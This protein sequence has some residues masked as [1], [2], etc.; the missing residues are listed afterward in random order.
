MS[1]KKPNSNS[2][3]EDDIGSLH[4]GINRLLSRQQER[5]FELLDEDVDPLAVINEKTMRMQ[6][7]WV[8]Q[9]EIGYKPSESE[10]ASQFKDRISKIREEAKRKTAQLR[11]VNED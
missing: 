8:E 5:M 3:S 4:N 7:K 6:M 9:N 11:V 2:A 10:E 1:N